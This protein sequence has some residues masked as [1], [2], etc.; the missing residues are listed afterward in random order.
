MPRILVID[1]DEQI[2]NM[3]RIMLQN[4]GYDVECAPEGKVALVLFSHSPFSLVIT[5]IVMP[6]KEGLETIMELKQQHPGVKIIAISGGGRVNPGHYLDGARALGAEF[7]FT[8]PVKL[9]RLLSAVR[10]LLKNSE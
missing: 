1:D 3:L 5:D 8:K 4:E 10:V 7:T 9:D 2:R 6:E